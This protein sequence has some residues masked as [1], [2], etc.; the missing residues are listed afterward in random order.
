MREAVALQERVG[1]RGVTD[2]E[3]RRITWRES[4][5]NAVDGYSSEKFPPAFGFR[6]PDGII[7]KGQPVPRVVGKLKKRR[8]MVTGNFGEGIG[9]G[10]YGPIADEERKLSRIVA[11]ARKVW[12]S[13]KRKTL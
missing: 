5:F 7:K 12:G 2:G 6:L 1:L 10:G 8:P 11:T 3:F 4:F 9:R 13:E